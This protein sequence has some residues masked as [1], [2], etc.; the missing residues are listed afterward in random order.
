MVDGV[1]GT[2]GFGGRASGVVVMVGEEMEGDGVTA[3]S[4]RRPGH[5]RAPSTADDAPGGVEQRGLPEAPHRRAE[6]GDRMPAGI[7]RFRTGVSSVG[8]GAAVWAVPGGRTAIDVRSLRTATHLAVTGE[9]RS[10]V[11][12]A[13]TVPQLDPGRK[14]EPVTRAAAAIEPFDGLQSD[15]ARRSQRGY[16]T[17]RGVLGDPDSGSHMPHTD[18]CC[19]A[20]LVATRRQGQV[21]Q[22]RPCHRTQPVSPFSTGSCHDQH[23]IAHRVHGT[24]TVGARRSGILSGLLTSVRSRRDDS[25]PLASSQSGALNDR[26]HLLIG[27]PFPRSGPKTSV[28]DGHG[29]HLH[30]L[31][32]G[33]DTSPVTGRRPLSGCWSQYCERP[34]SPHNQQRMAQGHQTT[35]KGGQRWRQPQRGTILGTS[36]VDFWLR[37]GLGTLLGTFWGTFLGTPTRTISA[38]TRGLRFGATGNK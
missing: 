15:Q 6:R 10:T 16:R 29:Y 26:H 33:N 20:R 31:A 22:R 8:V 2:V 38:W 34:S 17:R 5:R 3:G 37:H 35:S 24:G 18:R 32:P 7:R 13:R 25:R 9:I 36:P 27:V 19:P 1:G 11:L 12:T 23:R 28:A 4:R 14:V 30:R 21:L